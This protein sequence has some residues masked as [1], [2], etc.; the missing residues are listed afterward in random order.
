MNNILHL[1]CRHAT[2]TECSV[3][4]C[5]GGGQNYNQQFSLK[6]KKGKKDREKLRH[7]FQVEWQLCFSDTEQNK[8]IVCCIKN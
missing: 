8:N 4:Q 3:S 5:R 1:K 2:N 6:K 7:K